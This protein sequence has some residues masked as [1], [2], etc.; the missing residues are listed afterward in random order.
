MG[1][2]KYYSSSQVRH[3]KKIKG[4]L[5]RFISLELKYTLTHTL[6][7]ATNAPKFA[8]SLTDHYG[9]LVTEA[10]YHGKYALV[11]FGFTHCK[12]VCPRNLERLSDA[13]NQLG[14]DAD[15]INALYI[16]VD[17]ERDTP[18]QMG[19]FLLR[20]TPR[21]I[22]LTGTIDQIEHAKKSFHVFS[23]R[24]EDR[25]A[26]D[27]YTMPHTAF[28]YI[29][30]PDGRLLD[31]IDTSLDVENV[32]VRI[33]KALAQDLDLDLESNSSRSHAAATTPVTEGQEHLQVLDKKQVTSIR[34]I[35]NLSRQ[36]KGDWSNMMGPSD[37][38]DGFGAYRF[39]LSYAAYALALAHFHRLPAAPGVFQSTF[40]RII[41]KICEPD[42][43]YYWRDASTGGGAFDTPRGEPITN[44][45]EK[46]NIMYSAYLQ[47]L[48][49]LYNSLFNDDRYT[50]PGALTL[51]YEP[52][53]W[54]KAG[55]FHFEYDQ[56]SLND[57]VYWNMVEGGYLGVACEPWCV[58]QICN[59]PPI[60]G[61]RL[62]D[63][64]RG[65]GTDTAGE[66][67]KGYL[68][69]WEEY[70]GSVD[71]NG[72]Y[73]SLVVKHINQVM[74]S[75]GAWSDAW[76]ATLMHAWNPDFVK[77]HYPSQRA[78]ALVRHDDGTLSVKITMHPRAAESENITRI[79]QGGDFG[80][81]AALASEM[82]DTETLQG[83]LAYADKN[84]GPRVQNGGFT[85][86][87]SDTLFDEKGN[88]GL[89]TPM[90]A[91]ALLPLARLNVANGFQRLYAGPWSPKNPQHY[92]EPALTEVD[93][94]VDVYRA[95]YVA[96]KKTLL[97]DLAVYEA[98]K[99]GR[100]VISRAFGRGDWMLKRNGTLIAW[101]NST[102]M[103]GSNAPTDVQQDGETL[104][105]AVRQTEVTSYVLE[106]HE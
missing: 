86:A 4:C 46:D 57:R 60:L 37:L 78:K 11:F 2:G 103:V 88:Y 53:F 106:W 45:I 73:R 9:H 100:V 31:H 51:H 3:L 77:E 17:P 102:Q 16:S 64:L 68:K 52:Y 40:E 95:V 7:M 8:F 29:H 93:F 72:D 22:G 97:F 67:T 58:F 13:L 36:L 59:Q 27:G 75:L 99:R 1:A 48:V 96:E 65:D 74:P 63:E 10:N 55:E 25:T 80:W 79:M 39:Q 15:R 91:N 35:G 26:P 34:H 54:G 50:Q 18:E 20:H 42:V 12:R 76:C 6:T 49:L 87:R 90:Q 92:K 43:W 44:P 23:T 84:L 101:G 61:F 81:V 24:K 70:G 85:Y 71:A 98:D 82:G 69:A 105:L 14:R 89:S 33:K 41:K 66:V 83:L 19:K 56:K 21:F 38:N 32:T 5:I 94:S 30:G 47:T 28:T 62:S 104:R